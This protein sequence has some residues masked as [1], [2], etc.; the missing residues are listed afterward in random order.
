MNQPTQLR[1]RRILS[2]LL[3]RKVISTS[4]T[5]TPTPTAPCQRHCDGCYGLLHCMLP[6]SLAPPRKQRKNARRHSKLRSSC[7]Y[8]VEPVGS[9]GM[10]V[11]PHKIEDDA[12]LCNA[13]GVNLTAE[14]FKCLFV[15]SVFWLNVKRDSYGTQC[16]FHISH[17]LCDS[18]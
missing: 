2:T 6:L 1:Q 3:R 16:R 15:L 18:A 8:M 9:R 11:S 14:C 17:L 12:C 10:F 13:V 5:S 7:V 4:M